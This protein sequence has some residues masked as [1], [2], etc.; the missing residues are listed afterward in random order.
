VKPIAESLG[1]TSGPQAPKAWPS[2]PL[3]LLATDRLWYVQAPAI[4]AVVFRVGSFS[5]PHRE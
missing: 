5:A 4:S 3:R 1:V 2:D